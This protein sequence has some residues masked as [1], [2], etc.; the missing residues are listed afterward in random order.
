MVCKNR[1]DDETTTVLSELPEE[2]EGW[3]SMSL[4]LAFSIA[5]I[6][7]IGAAKLNIPYEYM[8]LYIAIIFAGGLAG[9]D[10]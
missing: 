10:D 2:Y 8:M 6:L 3:R 4:L 5:I 9:F 1:T 7:T